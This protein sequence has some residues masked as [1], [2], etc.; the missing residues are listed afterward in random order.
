MRAS[1]TF[2]NIGEYSI[3]IGRQKLL[4]GGSC[5]ETL[6]LPPEWGTNAKSVS[7][8]PDRKKPASCIVI[9]MESSNLLSVPDEQWA[10]AISRFSIKS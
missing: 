8:S 5:V 6:D 3:T 4:P 7:V 2:R 1:V 9:P 10:R